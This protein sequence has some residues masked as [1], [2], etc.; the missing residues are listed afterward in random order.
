MY[1]TKLLSFTLLS[2]FTFIGE[3][4]LVDEK[5]YIDDVKEEL[6]KTWPN[7]RAINLVFHGHSVPAGYFN[8]PSVRTMEAYPN[9]VLGKVKEKYPYAVV[10]VIKTCIGG[11]NSVRGAKR[12]EDDVL[13]HKPDVLF[14]DY[15]L[16]DLSLDM[17][18]TYKAWESMI[19]KA[20]ERNIKVILLTPTPDKRYDLQSDETVLAQH[21]QQIIDLASKHKVG[22]VD[23][24]DAFRKKV[25]QG[26]ALDALMSQVNHPNEFGH[27][28]VADAIL[29][30]F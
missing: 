20:K 11:E 25:K 29:K 18:A 2:W 6:V 22:L 8:T 1:L 19:I 24:Y 3:P 30:F 9:L 21:R 4:H 15:A 28:L 27:P 5:N 10:N 13:I 17:K 12:F 7:N 14:I 23:S 16:N 26:T